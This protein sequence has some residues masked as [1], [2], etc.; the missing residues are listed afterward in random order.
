[1]IEE[2]L[3]PIDQMSQKQDG[4]KGE[5]ESGQKI[6]FEENFGPVAIIGEARDSTTK[7][8]VEEDKNSL[9]EV[10]VRDETLTL[11][12]C[13]NLRETVRKKTSL[14]KGW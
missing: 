7:F 11:M 1:M 2:R 13:P 6:D 4:G 12:N 14:K 5:T 9:F 8:L 3:Q 10:T